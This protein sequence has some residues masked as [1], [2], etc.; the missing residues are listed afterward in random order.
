MNIRIGRLRLQA[1]GMSPEAAREFGRLVAERLGVLLEAAPPAPVPARVASQRVQICWPAGETLD[2]RAATA[3]AA[4]ARAL[5]GGAG[6]GG[7]GSGGA[8]SGGAGR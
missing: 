7:A 4:I 1:S 2:G 5:P 8:G 3:A 6:S